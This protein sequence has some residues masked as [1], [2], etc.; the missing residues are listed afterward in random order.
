MVHW[1]IKLCQVLYLFSP[2]QQQTVGEFMR[3]Q[4]GY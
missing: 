3:L 4:Y 2:A 1:Y